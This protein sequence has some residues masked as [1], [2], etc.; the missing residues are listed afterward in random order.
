[1]NTKKRN[2][3]IETTDNNL[4]IAGI[5]KHLSTATLTLAGASYTGAALWRSS[6]V[7]SPP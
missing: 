7:G 5:Q 6:K 1:M 3:I 2:K 4:L